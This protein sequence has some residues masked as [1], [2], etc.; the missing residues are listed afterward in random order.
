[1]T[2]CNARRRR[3]KFFKFSY[4]VRCKNIALKKK[5]NFFFFSVNNWGDLLLSP[6]LHA[7]EGPPFLVR[8][9]P[10]F[11]EEAPERPARWAEFLAR[12]GRHHLPRGR[13]FWQ[14]G[15]RSWVGASFLARS[16]ATSGAVNGQ[17]RGVGRFHWSGAP[18]LARGALF[19]VR[20]APFLTTGVPHWPKG[21]ALARRAPFMARRALYLGRGAVI[22]QGAQSLTRRRCSWPEERRS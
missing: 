4:H 11:W 6:L 18:F 9:A 7:Y 12:E 5:T 13:S 3:A 1:M 14:E 8:E 16:L 17:G 19:L 21:R 20:G 15:R 2:C 10:F 22:G